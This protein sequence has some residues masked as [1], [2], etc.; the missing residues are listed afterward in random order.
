MIYHLFYISLYFTI[1][2]N[3]VRGHSRKEWPP[4]ILNTKRWHKEYNSIANKT[5][6]LRPGN[7]F[8][9]PCPGAAGVV[10]PSTGFNSQYSHTLWTNTTQGNWSS[11]SEVVS[12]T[13]I[14][15]LGKKSIYNITNYLESQHWNKIELFKLSTKS[16]AGMHATSGHA[17]L[18]VW[19]YFTK[20]DT[21]LT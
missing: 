10:I 12:S 8:L 7:S 21:F 1:S 6:K 9:H 3:N 20:H 2:V 15:K 16:I 17:Y 19:I 5:M 13:R 14:R 11:V 4:S 18:T